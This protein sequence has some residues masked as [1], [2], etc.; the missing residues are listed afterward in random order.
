MKI[1]DIKGNMHDIKN[2]FFRNA[3]LSKVKCHWLLKGHINPLEACYPRDVN[4]LI[5][6][7]VNT[8]HSYVLPF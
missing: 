7:H 4:H 5:Q 6:D 1:D 3:I 8:L 2:L